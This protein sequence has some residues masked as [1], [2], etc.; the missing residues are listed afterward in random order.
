MRAVEIA[1]VI[2][3]KI[4]LKLL[5]RED[6]VEASF[7]LV[8]GAAWHEL[9]HPF[10]ACF[11]SACDSLPYRRRGAGNL[12]SQGGN[13]APCFRMFTVFRTQVPP[14]N[15]FP[16][17]CGGYAFQCRKGFFAKLRIA[18]FDGFGEKLVFAA[19]MFVKAANREARGLHHG[20]DA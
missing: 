7:S 10:T 14:D 17:L 9:Q 4:M 18:R 6:N 20:G 5:S 19:E 2:A 8:S 3:G 11:H 1:P 16:A 15:F 12:G 13:R